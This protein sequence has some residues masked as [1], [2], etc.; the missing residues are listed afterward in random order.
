MILYMDLSYSG[1]VG[2]FGGALDFPAKAEVGYFT[3]EL[4]VN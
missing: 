2:S 1:G 3:Y 4:G